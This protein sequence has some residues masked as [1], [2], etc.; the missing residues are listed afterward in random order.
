MVHINNR[1]VLQDLARR[2]VAEH[3]HRVSTELVGVGQHFLIGSEIE[4]TPYWR[5]LLY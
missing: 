2:P 4:F 1:E 3:L 5:S